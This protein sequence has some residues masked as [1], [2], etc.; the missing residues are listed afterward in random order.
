MKL[1]LVHMCLN[2]TSG[3]QVSVEDDDPAGR[4]RGKKRPELG[5]NEWLLY[6]GNASAHMELSV[7]Q[8][9]TSKNITGMR[10]APYLPDLAPC[11]NANKAAEI[12]DGVFD[13]NTVTA[14]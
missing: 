4:L 8:F 10:H 3:Y 6:Q 12:V 14:N 7:K 13:A 5:S 1:C 9:L 11:E 2:G